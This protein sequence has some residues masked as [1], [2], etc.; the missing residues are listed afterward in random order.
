MVYSQEGDTLMRTYLERAKKIM[1]QKKDVN[2]EEMQ[3]LRKE[4]T[5]TTDPFIRNVLNM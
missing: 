5:K 1:E 4:I 3:E 2:C